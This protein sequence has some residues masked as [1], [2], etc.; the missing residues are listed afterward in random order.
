LSAAQSVRPS[1]PFRVAVVGCGAVTQHY[2][3]PVLAGHER[4]RIAA[5][6]ELDT[7]PLVYPATEQS[8]RARFFAARRMTV[9]K[10]HHGGVGGMWP[11][12]SGA[13][14]F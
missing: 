5:L 12:S 8:C 11:A 13:C 1:T 3:L 4:F 14:A 2:H 6:V 7:V 10:D 9:R